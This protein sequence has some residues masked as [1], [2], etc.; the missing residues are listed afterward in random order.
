MLRI[1]VAIG[2]CW[3]LGSALGLVLL[4]GCSDASRQTGTQV[5]DS[6]E[7]KARTDEMRD[8]YKG[9]GKK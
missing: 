2:S 1:R 6:P 7:V 5:Q 3:L 9:M 8:M 4:G